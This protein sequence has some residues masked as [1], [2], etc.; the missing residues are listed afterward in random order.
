MLSIVLILKKITSIANKIYASG[1]VSHDMC[2][3]IFVIIPKIP[4]TLESNKHRT[5]SIM[6]QVLKLMLRIVPKRE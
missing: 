5:L 4:G 6:S 3:S 1:Q 2:K